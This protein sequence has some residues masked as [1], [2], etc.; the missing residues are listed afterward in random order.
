M[1]TIFWSYFLWAVFLQKKNLLAIAGI[2]LVVVYYFTNS[3]LI[4]E[5][6]RHELRWNKSTRAVFDYIIAT[7]HTLA[8]NTLIIAPY[9]EFGSQESTFFTEQLGRGEVRY[10]SKHNPDD[11]DTWEKQASASAHVIKIK[12][13]RNCGCIREE[14]IK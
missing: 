14:K 2:G 1:L 12:Y 11:V 5:N 13:D 10:M 7:R 9:P 6:F 4:K 8:K 3:L